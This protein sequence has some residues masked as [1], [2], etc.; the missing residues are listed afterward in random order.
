MEK[1]WR[2][3][4]EVGNS[5]ELDK[6][7]AV[8][9]R[10]LKRLVEYSAISIHLREDGALAPAYLAGVEF[11][12]L[13]ALEVYRPI[14]QEDVR[15]LADL[16]AVMAVPLDELGVA[17]VYRREPFSDGELE[18]LRQA[19]GKLLAAVRIA[20]AYRSAAAQAGLGGAAPLFRRLDAELSRCAREST[21]LAV[22]A[23]K[24]EGGREAREAA[25]SRLRGTCREYDFTAVSGDE[26][27]LVLAGFTPCDL[28]EKRSRIQA[29]AAA[30]GVSARV[31]AGF[32]PDDGKDAEDLLA[33]ASRRLHA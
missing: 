26:F 9:D 5:L 27:V 8:F 14:R 2:L 18:V 33:V 3:F 22:L 28:P 1:L 7:L 23:C 12:K 24:I 30:A 10:E 25:W 29:I 16:R 31:G 11:Q 32:F 4:R 17:A 15:G 19:A 21:A 20:V 6:T 13:P